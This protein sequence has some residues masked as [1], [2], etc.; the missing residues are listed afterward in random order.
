MQLSNASSKNKKN[1]NN[2]FKKIS[3]YKPSGIYNIE[4][5]DNIKKIKNS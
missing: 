5:L 1:E 3:S 4:I 2:N